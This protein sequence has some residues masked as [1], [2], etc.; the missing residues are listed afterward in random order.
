M[1]GGSKVPVQGINYD[2]RAY[3][4]TLCCAVRAV[5]PHTPRREGPRPGAPYIRLRLVVHT[6]RAVL[7]ACA[8]PS[9]HVRTDASKKA[10]VAV[11]CSQALCPI[12]SRRLRPGRRGR[13]SET[14]LERSRG[15]TC[16]LACILRVFSLLMI[17]IQSTYDLVL[18]KTCRPLEV[19]LLML[20]QVPRSA[21]SGRWSTGE[22]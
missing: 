5:D 4:R 6:S 11:S 18:D 16:F 7:R 21:P 19:L 20:P 22:T 17:C 12:C 13:I 1:S 3:R 8:E 15:T 14:A 2:A 10:E 9:A